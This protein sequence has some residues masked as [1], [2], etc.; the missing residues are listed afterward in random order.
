M[1]YEDFVGSG[2]PAHRA[3]ET[4]C[5]DL[6]RGLQ[7]EGIVTSQHLVDWY[8][9]DYSSS[10]RRGGYLRRTAQERLL[11]LGNAALLEGFLGECFA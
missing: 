8:R 5:T 6:R 1:Y 2:M 7:Q 9:A 11:E 3:I 4:A 10:V